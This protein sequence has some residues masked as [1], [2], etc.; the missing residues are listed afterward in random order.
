MSIAD[1]G[2][3]VQKDDHSLRVSVGSHKYQEYQYKNNILNYL[4]PPDEETLEARMYDT[5]CIPTDGSTPAR[6]AVEHGIELAEAF[7]ATVHALY[8]IETKAHYIFTAAGHDREE[9]EEYREYGKKLVEQ[10]VDMAVEAGLDGKGAVKTGS[11]A[12]E[13]VEY[14]ASNGIDCIVMGAQGRSGIDDYLVGST[15]EK[16]VRTSDVPVTT[17]RHREPEP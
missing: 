13:I 10:V 4:R 9:M 14:A 3:V 15:T 1:D 2:V 17:I 16:V 12:Q 7:D 5:I 11:V 8:V 6:N